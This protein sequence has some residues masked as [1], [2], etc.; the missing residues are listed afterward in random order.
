MHDLYRE[1]WDCRLNGIANQGLLGRGAFDCREAERNAAMDAEKYRAVQAN[2]E[3]KEN[4]KLL[5]LG[6]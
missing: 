6:D 4:K 2:K 5:L 1:N 3:S